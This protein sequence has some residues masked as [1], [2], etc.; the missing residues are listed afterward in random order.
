M[1]TACNSSRTTLRMLFSQMQPEPEAQGLA[2]SPRGVEDAAPYK[3]K[4]QAFRQS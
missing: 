1:L 2:L 3:R 4:L